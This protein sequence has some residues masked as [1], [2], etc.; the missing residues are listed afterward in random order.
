MK[1][2]PP[3]VVNSL[4]SVIQQQ[5][6][7]SKIR[8][9]Q[10]NRCKIATS[11]KWD[12]AWYWKFFRVPNCCFPGPRQVNAREKRCALVRLVL[13]GR[14]HAGLVHETVVG[15]SPQKLCNKTDP[16][17]QNWVSE[18]HLRIQSRALSIVPCHSV[19]FSP[20]LSTNFRP[21]LLID[22]N[23]APIYLYWFRASLARSRLP[24]QLALLC[25]VPTIYLQA[26][27]NAEYFVQT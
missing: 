12:K 24:D 17:E 16:K 11:T 14:Y 3:E 27:R 7:C 20:R 8:S 21:K 18:R 10:Q 15:R 5:N 1:G 13:K 2:G 19:C 23:R 6:R 26:K 9:E 22:I 4:K 25:S